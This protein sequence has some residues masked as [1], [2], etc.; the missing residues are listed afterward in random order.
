MVESSCWCVQ[1]TYQVKS[2]AIQRGNYVVGIYNYKGRRVEADCTISLTVT[3]C[4]QGDNGCE[5]S[6]N[7]HAVF[8]TTTGWFLGLFLLAGL[9][10]FCFVPCCW[11]IRR[12]RLA[13]Q[14]PQGHDDV[15]WAGNRLTHARRPPRPNPGLTSEQISSVPSFV[16]EPGNA[17]QSRQYPNLQ[18]DACSVCLMEFETG[19]M[20][21][22]NLWHGVDPVFALTRNLLTRVR[23]V[24]LLPPSLRDLRCRHVFHSDCIDQW[25]RRQRTCPLCKGDAM[26]S[27]ANDVTS[28]TLAGGSAAVALDMPNSTEGVHEADIDDMPGTPRRERSQEGPATLAQAGTGDEEEAR[29]ARR[30]THALDR[31][32]PPN[33][34]REPPP[35]PRSTADSGNSVRA[36]APEQTDATGRQAE[37]TQAGGMLGP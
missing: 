9:P 13:H 1:K 22:S 29:P 33:P 8:H 28:S 26:H 37:A 35:L 17:D 36:V 5:N 19:D 24:L 32:Q 31:L 11:C 20:Y 14:R 16:Y 6:H 4:F 15:A 21:V 2:R 25:L 12:L 18:S 23:C 3:A 27:A 7:S 10:L 34:G 30:Q